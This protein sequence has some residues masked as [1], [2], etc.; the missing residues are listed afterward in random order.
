MPAPLPASRREARRA[1]TSPPR[2][3]RSRR[4]PSAST[5]AGCSRPARAAGSWRARRVAD[6][7]QCLAIPRVASCSSSPR[8]WPGEQH[9]L[10]WVALDPRRLHRPPRGGAA[11]RHLFSR[12]AGKAF[13]RQQHSRKRLTGRLAWQNKL[14][15]GVRASSVL[16]GKLPWNAAADHPLRRAHDHGATL[17][18]PS[19]SWP[20]N[21]SA[22]HG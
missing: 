12:A 9:L 16:R 22:P 6:A 17:E 11:S 19:A 3:S 13:Q 20:T 21:H 8:P 2:A 15:S 1:W 18:P 14:T 4:A 7:L 10:H 5:S